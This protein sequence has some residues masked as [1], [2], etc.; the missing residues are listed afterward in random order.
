MSEA[1]EIPPG[2]ALGSLFD[3]EPTGA[4]STLRELD[5]GGRARVADVCGLNDLVLVF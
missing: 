5:Q 1:V 3:S 4:P 2:D